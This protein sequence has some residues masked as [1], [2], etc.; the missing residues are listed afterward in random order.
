MMYRSPSMNNEN[1]RKT[2]LC[3][4]LFVVTKIIVEE[5]SAKRD[6]VGVLFKGGLDD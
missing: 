5:V 1:K 4:R 6:L 3:G 2:V